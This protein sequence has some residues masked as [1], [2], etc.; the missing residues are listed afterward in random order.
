MRRQRVADPTQTEGGSGRPPTES[1]PVPASLRRFVASSLTSVIYV[2]RRL[3][4][5][6]CLILAG[7][8]FADEPVITVLSDFEDDSVA[9]RIADVHNLLKSDC[10][11]TTT[12]IP[13]RGQRA[14]KL[15]IG[16]T[17]RDAS[18][19]CAL[20]FRLAT[21]F[22]SADRIATYCWINGG[23][24]R[25]AFR[26]RD[27]G[28]QLFETEPTLVDQA[29]RW[30]RVVEDV[31]AISLRPLGVPDDA[32]PPQLKW[33]IQIEG[34]RI[35]VTRV[36]RQVVFLDDLEVEHRVPD[37]QVVRADF[38]F[39]EPTHLYQ[40]G[41]VVRAAVALENCSRT[42]ALRLNVRLRWLQSDGTEFEREQATINLPA[43]GSDYRS[44]QSVDFSQRIIE[45]GFYRLVA[46]VRDARWSTDAHF[47]TSISVQPSNRALPRGRE[48][49][50]GVRANLLR[51]PLVD[52]R[53]EIDLAR[54]IGAQLFV[55]ETPWSLVEPEPQHFEF[56]GL[57]EIVDQ[58]VHRDIAV[59][60]AVTDPP[61]WLPDDAD[62]R[63]RH[64]AL[65]I[66]A[67][68]SRF[69]QRV[70][71][72][73]A[74]DISG[75]EPGGSGSDRGSHL[76]RIRE[77]VQQR[78]DATRSRAEVY[79]P[80][81]S[82][83][84]NPEPL[85]MAAAPA[86][87]ILRTSG[88]TREALE[89][90]E[91]FAAKNDW[92][93]KPTHRWMHQAKP[94]S[95]PGSLLDAVA[96]LRYCVRAAE[97]GVGGIIWFDLRDDT[98]DPRHLEAMRGMVR[99]DYSPKTPLLGFA[100]AVG[101]LHG[102]R[103]LGPLPGTPEEFDSYLFLGGPRQVAVLF[104]KPGRILPAA[105]TPV[106]GVEGNFTFLD[107]ERRERPVLRSDAPPLVVSQPR[108]AF[109][110]FDMP[111]ID[112]EP[113]IALA[114]AWL[115]APGTVLCGR[116]CQFEVQVTAPL[117][118]ERSYIRLIIPNQAP[119]ESA[120]SARRVRADA[121]DLV[122]FPI[123][124]I[125]TTAE[126]FKPF[127]ITVRFSLEG[128]V[129]DLPIRV[130]PVTAIPAL[131]ED[132]TPHDAAYRVAR[133]T[134]VNGDTLR[135]GTTD[136]GPA[137]YAG[138]TARE[139]VLRITRVPN[140]ARDA[141]LECGIAAPDS[142]R[143]IQARVQSP[144][145]TPELAPLHGTPAESLAGWKVR[146]LSGDEGLRFCELRVPAAR[147]GLESLRAG[148]HLYVS[149]AV[150]ERGRILFEPRVWTF[151]GEVGSNYSISEYE[152]IRLGAQADEP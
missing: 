36:G 6:C 13:A 79:A 96:V 34:Y 134:Q 26:I 108:P 46:R 135:A 29:H 8:S 27:A 132:Q 16:A 71:Y 37:V 104:P 112:N 139:L 93:W 98:N 75:L 151:G 25:L 56:E 7:V 59:M 91:R 61:A 1:A 97:R 88:D 127:E 44:R 118:L 19:G 147:L 49:F 114:P 69:G 28:G 54:E 122:R 72:Y 120:F 23:A 87:L 106:R 10:S 58:L 63:L 40:P 47:E 2:A 85:R 107:F 116:Q 30:V 109:L 121:G 70:Q 124:L 77:T 35:G 45:P 129:L 67:T 60:L 51:E 15:Q 152:W 95:D 65:F 5:A 33:P 20:R 48:T 141:V 101:M 142:A 143:P 131:S 136:D 38:R 150:R 11:I 21:P 4:V 55:L 92:S 64:Q 105:L 3:A 125:R 138:Y 126:S 68:A 100:S 133:L 111:R 14:L 39:D 18:L 53:L 22:Q 149:L 89:S 99:R 24:V 102:L 76:E 115:R 128:Q 12:P 94:T 74:H 80:P 62:E 41:S 42:R 110:V 82:I 73:E 90:L 130:R 43:S 119:V 84:G 145:D 86:R 113:Q 144:W 81:V 146:A 117:D 66:E 137:L 17:V 52:Q 57:Q 78:V 148:Q 103:Y 32:R 140:L 123:T 83:S 50:F 9:V 31:S